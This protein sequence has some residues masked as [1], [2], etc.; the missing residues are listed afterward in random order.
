MILSEQASLPQISWPKSVNF[1][2]KLYGLI[3]NNRYELVK[4]WLPYECCQENSQALFTDKVDGFSH[5]MI[6]LGVWGRIVLG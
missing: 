1:A 5:G 6:N 4:V 3:L 2:Y